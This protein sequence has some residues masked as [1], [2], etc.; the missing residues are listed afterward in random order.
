[1]EVQAPVSRLPG[2]RLR[3][4]CGRRIRYAGRTRQLR[5]DRQIRDCHTGPSDSV[6]TYEE[7]VHCDLG[8]G[9]YELNF[10]EGVTFTEVVRRGES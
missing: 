1:M 10:A 3:I 5:P 4:R 9:T 7:C 6:P 8:P 2:R